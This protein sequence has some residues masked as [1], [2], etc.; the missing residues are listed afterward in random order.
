MIV[1]GKNN[2]L[3]LIRKYIHSIDPIAEILLYGFRAR[4]QGNRESDCDILVL[5]DYPV[6]I[7]VERK[8]SNKIYDLELEVGN[9]M[10]VFVYN[11]NDREINQSITSFYHNVMQDGVRL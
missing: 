11:K 1:S 3:N 2:I 6:D 5:T 10:S 9:T 7:S 4:G 8:F